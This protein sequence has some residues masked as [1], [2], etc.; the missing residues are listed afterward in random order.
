MDGT[1]SNKGQMRKL[2]VVSVSFLAS[3]IGAALIPTTV[4]T[5]RST[6]HTVPAQSPAIE[7]QYTASL[8]DRLAQ[9]DEVRQQLEPVP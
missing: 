1:Q 9:I 3:L 2:T 7:Y 4:V 8:Q 5:G 6:L